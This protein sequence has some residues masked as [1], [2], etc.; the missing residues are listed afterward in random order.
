VILLKWNEKEILPSQSNISLKIKKPSIYSI[1]LPEI[2][3][4]SIQD[5]KG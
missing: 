5:E 4:Y 2:I 3:T 1:K